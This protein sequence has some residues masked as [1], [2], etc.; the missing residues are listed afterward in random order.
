MEQFQAREHPV[1]LV[2]NDE[3]RRSRVTV[4]FRLLLALP[5]GQYPSLGGAP[6]A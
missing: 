5:T 2:N 4:F 1:R 6:T 3:L